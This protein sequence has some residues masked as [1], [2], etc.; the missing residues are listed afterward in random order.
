MQMSIPASTSPWLVLC[1][2]QMLLTMPA[3]D[4]APRLAALPAALG[5]T[6]DE[7]LALL[8]DDPKILQ[9]G[10]DALAAAWV[11]LRRAASMRAEWREQ[12][13]GWTATTFRG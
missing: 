4:V 7:A 11:E 10:S 5:I 1:V 9:Q 2:L 13:G 3:P 8:E 6:L 12:I